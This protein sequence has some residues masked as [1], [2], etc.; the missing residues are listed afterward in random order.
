M[1]NWLKAEGKNDDI[2]ISSRVRLA[3]NIKDIPFPDKLS[4]EKGKEI[5]EMINDSILDLP[6]Y[7]DKFKTTKLWESDSLNNKTYFEKHLISYK[8]LSNYKKA[9]FISDKDETI[10]IMLNEEDHIR[11]QCI[12]SSLNLEEAYDTANNLDNLIESK[13]DYAYDERLGYLTAC[14]T[15]VGTGMR[16]SVMM[17]LPALSISNEITD[18]LKAVSQVGMTIRGLYGEGSKVSG[19]LYQISNQISLGITEKEIMNNLNA[20]INQII[21]QENISRQKLMQNYSYE[22]EDRMHRAL[23]ILKSARLLDLSEGLN[24]ISQVRLGVELGIIK[25]VDKKLL[26]SLLVNTQPAM[27]QKI[28]NTKLNEKDKNYYRARIVRETLDQKN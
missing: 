14:P 17:H 24:L 2:V 21:N 25:N 4:D 8:L 15:N 20:V 10:S 19:N 6:E 13:V 27:L 5:V 22:I 23:G 26:N 9:A 3:R 11:I 16:A 28:F 7:K 1:E 12:T 18:I